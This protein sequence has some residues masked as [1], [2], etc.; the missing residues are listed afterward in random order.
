LGN[1]LKKT[2][3]LNFEKTVSVEYV[4]ILDNSV[5]KK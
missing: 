1:I 3:E 5:A 4:Q 2:Q